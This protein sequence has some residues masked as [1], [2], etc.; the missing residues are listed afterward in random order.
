MYSN[1]KF[2][3]L[4][5][6]YENNKDNNMVKNN[7]ISY[8]TKHYNKLPYISLYLK[9]KDI[10]NNNKYYEYFLKTI[11]DNKY[12]DKNNNDINEELD[13]YKLNN[14]R[15][16]RDYKNKIRQMYLVCQVSGYHMLG[17]E[18]A[19][20]WEFKD[21]ETTEDKYHKFNGLLLKTQIHR[22]WDAGY[23]KLGYNL[24]DR[25]I[26]FMIDNDKIIN[27]DNKSLFLDNLLSEL[28]LKNI[29]DKCYVNFNKEYFNSYLH[30]IRR[31][32]NCILG[33]KK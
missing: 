10:K 24:N 27:I 19:H 11:I 18:V 9:H 26:Y 31:R 3:K 33:N 2:Q 13:K 1:I 20:I 28:N 16:D 25:T 22:Y 17:C 30:F 6:N 15:N 14:I 29:N 8:I 21:C 5:N 32:D 23:I 7:L 12:I 4:V